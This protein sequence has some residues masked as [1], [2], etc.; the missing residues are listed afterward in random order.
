MS[1]SLSFFT[2]E[3]PDFLM[4]LLENEE[5]EEEYLP[6]WCLRRSH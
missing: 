5:E 1:W 4:S 6:V 2:A 3:G